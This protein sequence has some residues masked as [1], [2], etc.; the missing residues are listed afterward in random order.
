MSPNTKN[1]VE[2]TTAEDFTKAM[3]AEHAER[4]HFGK[5]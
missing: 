1:N 2:I 3:E 4:G 5:L